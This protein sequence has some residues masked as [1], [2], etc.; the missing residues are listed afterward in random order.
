MRILLPLFI[1]LGL[2]FSAVAT[3]IDKSNDIDD[4]NARVTRLEQQ[5]ATLEKKVA[6]L[7]PSVPVEEVQLNTTENP[8]LQLKTWGYREIQIKFNTYYALDISLINNF[9]KAIV[10][11]D[12]RL[13]FKNRQGGHL[14]SVSITPNSHIP[15]N[16][17][18][19]DKGTR[20]NKRL[21][22][23]GHQIIRLAREDIATQLI[24][25]ELAFEDGSKLVFK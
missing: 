19:I 17:S 18:F 12:A 23:R 4:L 2:S 7:S 10:A 24:I 25:R 22:G 13:Q 1:S 21:L 15:A 8:A 14:Y 16:A 6:G 9:D 11:L 20:E 3:E 5:V